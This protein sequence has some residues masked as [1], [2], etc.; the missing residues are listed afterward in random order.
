MALALGGC[1]VWG[2]IPD[3]THPDFDVRE[4]KLDSQY[5]TMGLGIMPD[6]AVVLASINE[7][8]GGEIPAANPETKIV[9]IRGLSC[10][11]LPKSVQTL[12]SGWR[13]ISGVTVVDGRIYV[14]DRDGFYK[15][16]SSADPADSASSRSLVLKWP[17]ENF[18]PMGLYWHQW[19]FTPFYWRGSFYA[20][21]SGS[22]HG[23]GWSSADPTTKLSGAFLKWD[24]TGNLEA[25]AG[26]LRSPNG[27]AVDENTGEFFVTDNQ[28]GWE[29]SSTFLRIR[30]H[31]FYGHRQTPVDTDAL[32]SVVARHP[33]NFA[34]SMPY[35]PPIA[36]LPHISVRSSPSQPVQLPAGEF[37]GDWLIGDV[38]NRGL[39]RVFLDRVGAENESAGSVSGGEGDADA[40]NG[41]VFWFSKGMQG[42]A[43]NRMVRDHSGGI[44]IGTITT[45]AGNW[46]GGQ[47]QPLFRLSPKSP[48]TAF[49]IATVRS[50]GDG[51]EIGFTQPVALD[52]LQPSR[53]TLKQWRYVR[54]AEYGQGRQG[55]ETLHASALEVSCD[56]RRVHVKVPGLATDH[57]VYIR[58]P[59]LTSAAGREL[60]NNEAWF[61]LNA[62]STRRFDSL[63]TYT[64]PAKRIPDG[65]MPRVIPIGPSS[66]EVTWGVTG[67]WD[68][69]L[70]TTEGRKLGRWRSEAGRTLRLRIAPR[71]PG[72]CVLRVSSDARAV[73]LRLIF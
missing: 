65:G 39:V 12:A 2:E 6:G 66:M 22:I 73:T 34:E 16:T 17:N 4:V 54:Q 67:S 48:A 1:A 49:D 25:Y 8:G 57:V 72:L 58:F 27:A 32:G 18:W 59:A 50:V 28:G 37:A 51:L 19:A 47:T 15:L 41:A 61:T 35:D 9:L 69:D 62:I 5:K 52:S 53:V 63:A 21:Y 29:P 43:V 13:Q 24:T 23:G 14:A 60:W 38:N 36:W 70:F 40:I 20:P 30:P 33:P 68:A 7:L 42:A 64:R 45:I 3:T 71:A 44:L 55:D 31:R 11:S 26:G 10:D 46:P 56:R